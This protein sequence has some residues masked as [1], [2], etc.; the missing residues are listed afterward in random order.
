MSPAIR[1]CWASQDGASL[2]GSH[3]NAETEPPR[4]SAAT[5]TVPGFQGSLQA[6]PSKL[7]L[8]SLLA[9]LREARSE[10][11][12]HLPRSSSSSNFC[13]EG[14]RTLR[15][16]AFIEWSRSV[17]KVCTVIEFWRFKHRQRASIS[18]TTHQHQP[19][20]LTPELWPRPGESFERV[21]ALTFSAPAAGI[22]FRL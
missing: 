13:D 11:E 21:A 14:S 7:G 9:E 8:L 19:P 2:C 4:E 3:Q 18:I 15:S 20:L 6:L 12:N 1:T 17:P 16:H 22:R 5:G 10:G